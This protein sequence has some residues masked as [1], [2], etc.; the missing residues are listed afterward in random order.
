MIDLA[1]TKKK[2]RIFLPEMLDLSK[3]ENIKPYFD[4]LLERAIETPAALYNWI[5]DRSELEAILS[6]YSSRIWIRTTC[7]T[8]DKEGKELL[9]YYFTNIETELQRNFHKLNERFIACEHTADLDEN[10]FGLYKKRIQTQMSFFKPENVELN[11]Q[12]S[13]KCAKYGEISAAM[14]VEIEGQKVTLQKAN[15]Y[16]KNEN[17]ALREE[18]FTKVFNRRKEDETNLN[19]LF[20]ELLKMR[21]TVASNAGYD[22]FRDYMF[23]ELCRFDYNVDDCFKFHDA[24]EKNIVPIVEKILQERKH[25][26]KLTQLRPWD[27]AADLPGREPLKPFNDGRDLIN[28]TIHCFDKLHPF[29]AT[30]IKTMDDHKH[31]D[32]D[33][34]IGKAPGGYMSPLY[35]TL[36]PFIFM[37]G[38]GTLKDVVTMV[39]EGGHAF[40]EFLT[41]KYDVTAFKQYPSEIAELASMSME[42]LTMDTWDAYFA[43]ELDQVR[44]KK[45]HL[46]DVLMALPWIATIDAFQHWIYTN[47]YHSIE[48]RSRMWT[49]IYQRFHPSIVDWSGLEHFENM[50]WQRQLHL[51]ECPFYYIEYGM[52]QL[53]AIAIF[54]NFKTDKT[55]T[56]SN[57]MHALSLGY[58]Q[59][60]PDV[61]QTAGIRFDFSNDYIKALAQF[62]EDELAKLN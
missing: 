33:S 8:N 34:R 6:E 36:I 57:Y 2:Q 50:L 11:A 13:I 31:L 3:W 23:D 49:Q 30:C 45:E 10:M 1:I 17:R 9:E 4:D 58:T 60:I 62:V 29:F 12:I 32:L 39:H 40:H 7:D 46:E 38:V 55:T 42:L 35:E 21:N 22:N 20:S 27:T 14:T 47:P 37:N 56:L 15:S 52:A 19:N 26:L 28:K 51:F 25:R 48:E 54:K 44:A 61:Y 24:I 41:A 53:G 43:S 59:S 5:L 18:A 16:L